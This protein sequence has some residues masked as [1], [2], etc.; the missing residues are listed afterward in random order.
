MTTS[1]SEML[2]NPSFPEWIDSIEIKS[3]SIDMLGLR[4]PVN[5]IGNH[6]FSGITTI[7]QTVRYLS[8]RA[9]I[10]WTYGQLR[11]PNNY[12]S[13]KDFFTRME[14]AVVMGSLL[15]D[16]ET[17]GLVG[18]SKAQDNI[19]QDGDP[20]TLFPLVET[21]FATNIYKGASEQLGIDAPPTGEVPKLSSER[22]LPLA[23]EFEIRVRDTRFHR[24]LY[25][26]P[27]VSS[28]PRSVL[29]ELGAAV[30]P[31][32]LSGT[33]KR[34]LLDAI[35]PDKPNPP[36]FQNGRID[37]NRRMGAYSLLLSLAQRCECELADKHLWEAAISGPEYLPQHLNEVL[38]GWLV[39]L[40][41]DMLAVVHEKCLDLALKR[42]PPYEED[43]TGIEISRLLSELVSDPNDMSDTLSNLGLLRSEESLQELRF[44]ELEKRIVDITPTTF[45]SNGLNR[46]EGDLQEPRIIKD[47]KRS[48]NGPLALLP[49]SWILISKRL[50]DGVES[51]A[52]NLLDRTSDRLEINDLLLKRVQQFRLKNQ[53][54]LEVIVELVEYSLDQHMRIA[55]SRFHFDEKSVALFFREEDRLIRLKDFSGDRTGSRVYNAIGWLRQ[56]ELIAADGITAAGEN[57]LNRVLRILAD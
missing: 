9:W 20:L 37:E 27:N 46:W 51:D 56:L 31:Q 13:F 30:H 22:G 18:I 26:N 25:E 24:L 11:Q 49:V 44:C 43:N 8:I 42:V 45:T 6:Y 21:Q 1:K 28:I 36:A 2:P 16:S 7:T 3:T 53:S 15:Y 5:V 48:D 47:T 52:R 10:I 35:L 38:D 19:A 50:E 39:Y 54:I 57:E 29:E 12:K 40:M 4:N 32:Q 41:R 34:L 55:L 17:S 14:C 33:E 23:N